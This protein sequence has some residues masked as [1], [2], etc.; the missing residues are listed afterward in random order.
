MLPHDHV[1]LTGP[2]GASES[3][4]LGHIVSRLNILPNRL[5]Y[6]PQEI[7][8]QSSKE[9]LL[10]LRSL[11]R[12]KLG[13]MMA[14]VSRVGS[15][16]DRLMESG[17]PSPGEMRKIL[18]TTA[19]AQK[20]Y[21]I[22]MDEPTNHLDLASIECLEEALADWPCGLFLVSHDRRFLTK[23]TN[24]QWSIESSQAEMVLCVRVHDQPSLERNSKVQLSSSLNIRMN[25]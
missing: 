14:V 24:T 7:D 16:P 19:I 23:L 21:L 17:E 20:P 3:T 10:Q 13:Q 4:L 2:N 5:T 12:E 8:L 9:I 1:A 6:I 11:P 25:R 15:N 22:V 18:L